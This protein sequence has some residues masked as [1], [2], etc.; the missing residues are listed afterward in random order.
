MSL[1][2]IRKIP[3][4]FFVFLIVL[5]QKIFSLDQ[6]FL[7]IFFPYR[8]VCRFV[9]TCSEYTKEAILEW[10]VLKGVFL[11]IKRILKCHPYFQGNPYDPPPKK[12]S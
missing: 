10:G 11:G 5:Y 12:Q 7:R 3:Q 4:K 1:L 2:P 8:R 6:G 9:P